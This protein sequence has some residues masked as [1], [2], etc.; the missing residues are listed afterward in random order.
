M[1]TRKTSEQALTEGASTP[2]AQTQRFL[3]WA[4]SPAPEIPGPRHDTSKP[5]SR[6][7]K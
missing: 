1:R 4:R 6:R 5:K 3:E 7:K 2:A